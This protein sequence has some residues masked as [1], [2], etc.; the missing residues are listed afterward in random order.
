M[1]LPWRRLAGDD[2]PNLA[3]RDRRAR[4]P[5]PRPLLDVPYVPQSEELCGGAAVAMV[6]RFWGAT[7]I[8][9]ESFS[10]LVDKRAR[11]IR[12]EDLIRSLHERGWQASSFNG[13][14]RSSSAA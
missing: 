13:D 8:Y 14:R 4:E 6:M 2:P 1:E 7:G 9:A 11:G 3:N 5:R 12:G 10:S